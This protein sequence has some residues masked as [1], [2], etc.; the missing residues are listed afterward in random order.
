[1]LAVPHISPPKNS[2]LGLWMVGRL[3]RRSSSGQGRAVEPHRKEGTR[4]RE[5][6][7]KGVGLVIGAQGR[8]TVPSA[9]LDDLQPRRAN[10]RG[11]GCGCVLGEAGGAGEGDYSGRTTGRGTWTDAGRGSSPG[12]GAAKTPWKAAPHG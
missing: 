6:R 5:E 12:A 7:G 3:C 10:R 11:L 2:V 4:V 9:S 8:Y 1:M